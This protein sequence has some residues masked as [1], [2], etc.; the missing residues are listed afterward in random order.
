MIH[1]I[2][3]SQFIERRKILCKDLTPYYFMTLAIKNDYSYVEA[4]MHSIYIQIFKEF[5]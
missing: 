3:E 4:K 1:N 5:K 2:E